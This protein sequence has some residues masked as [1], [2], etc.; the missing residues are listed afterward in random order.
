MP[1]YDGA[2]CKALGITPVDAQLGIKTTI[3]PDFF[4]RPGQTRN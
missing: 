2:G 3:P 1:H 4:A